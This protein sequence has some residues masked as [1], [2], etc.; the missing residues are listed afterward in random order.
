MYLENF[1]KE[2][3]D[4][5]VALPY[6]VGLWISATDDTGGHESDAVEKQALEQVIVAYVEDFCLSL[7]HI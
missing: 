5:L 7:I 2:Q 4:F 6:R 3:Q 1:S